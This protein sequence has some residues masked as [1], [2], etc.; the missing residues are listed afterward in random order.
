MKLTPKQKAFA[1]EYLICGNATEADDGCA[2]YSKRA[3]KV[4]WR[5]KTHT[6]HTTHM[7]NNTR[8]SRRKADG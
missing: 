4:L 8:A 3:Q 2:D 7:Y 5:I 1:D 6:K